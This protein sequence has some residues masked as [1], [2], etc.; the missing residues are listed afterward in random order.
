MRR[1]LGL[2]LGALAA[3][4][5]AGPQ[6]A[7]AAWQDLGVGAR[8]LGMGGAVA[9]IVDDPSAVW[10]NPAGL[11]RMQAKENT[12]ELSLDGNVLSENRRLNHLGYAY[13]QDGVGTLGLGLSQYGLTGL[14]GY[15]ADG[16]PTGSFDDLGLALFVDWAGEVNWHLRYGVGLR[17]LREQLG[18]DASWGYAGDLGILVLPFEGSAAALA[19]T[20]QNLVSSAIWTTGAT[21]QAAPTLRLGLS[22]RPFQDYLTLSAD[23]EIG[24]TAGTL[25]PH[26]G[27]ELWP[28]G[29][30]GF[31][32][33]WQP[34]QG[35]S[36]GLSWKVS[37]YQFDYGFAWEP[38]G[39]GQRHEASIALK[40]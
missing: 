30:W 8:A 13:R 6:S 3:A 2:I 1:A 18:G 36:G 26:L 28:R 17:A 16:S 37:Y 23:A 20:A 21:E 24:V 7:S 5:Q 38:L 15:D 27:A 31:R 22:D 33:G 9:S 34:G 11:S 4:A 29:D 10:W 19:V 25:I 14:E 32:G 40:L 39:L 12:H 35:L